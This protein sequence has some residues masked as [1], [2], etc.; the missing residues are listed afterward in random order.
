MKKTPFGILPDGRETS[1]YTITAGRFEVKIT[2]YGAAITSFSVDGT[3]VILG[4]DDLEGYLN[5][6][7]YMGASI[8]RVGN[9]IAGGKFTLEGVDYTLAINN[10][11]NC[12]HG[13]LEGFDKKLWKAEPMGEKLRMVYVSRD[14]EEGFP[15]ELTVTEDFSLSEDGALTIEVSAIT[16]RTTILN[17]TNH[18]YFNLDGH[19]CGHDTLD[20][21]IKIYADKVGTVDEYCL[22]TGE[23]MDV[24]GTVFDLDGTHRLSGMYPYTDRQIINANGI[25]HSFPVPGEGIRPMLEAE[26]DLSGIKLTVLSDQPCVHLYT[27][28]YI[29][30][31]RVGKGGAKYGKHFGYAIETQNLPNAINNP[32]A[33]SPVLRPGEVYR[34]TTKFILTK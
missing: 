18:P 24:A 27:G 3:D 19:D 8:G 33:P 14:M 2:D 6:G 4:F 25:D 21:R 34:H 9:R 31:D 22:A 7:E 16:D 10:G 13:G 32:N 30:E 20:Q 1:L 15:G 17:L 26:S 29:P 5:H 28:N 23:F 12:N 11:P